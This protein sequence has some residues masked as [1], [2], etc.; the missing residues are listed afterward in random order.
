MFIAALVTR[1]KMWR[2]PTWM[3]GQIDNRGTRVAME[4]DSALPRRE[5]LTPATAWMHQEDTVPR[6]VSRSQDKFHRIPCM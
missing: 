3:D 6:E 1:A 4:H 2:P 5:I